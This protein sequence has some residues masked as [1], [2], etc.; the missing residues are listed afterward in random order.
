MAEFLINDAAFWLSKVPESVLNTHFT[1][2]ADYI[3]I[4]TA[5]P[6]FILPEMEKR[7]DANRP[8]NGHEFATYTCNNYWTHPA[9]SFEDEMNVGYAGRLG[10]RSVSGTVATALIETGVTS[11]TASM[12]PIASGRQNKASDFISLEGGASFLLAGGVVERFRLFQNRADPPRFQADLLF[13]GKHI[14]PH[15][16]TSLP[17]TVD[18]IQCRH[19][20]GRRPSG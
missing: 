7:N 11:Y 4:L 5:N 9:V 10:L 2:G 19:T 12:L 15:G 17:T 18:I 20:S 13:S 1:A 16:V 14:R 6:F 8:G 3:K